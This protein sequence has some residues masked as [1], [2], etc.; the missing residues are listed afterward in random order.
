ME[1]LNQALKRILDHIDALLNQATFQEPAV[2][3]RSLSNPGG[4]PLDSVERLAE[5]WERLSE[6][7]VP[8]IVAKQHAKVSANLLRLVIDSDSVDSEIVIKAARAYRHL[9]A[10]HPPFTAE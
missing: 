5:A 7:A 10:S 3:T 6:G 9:A 4:S 8:P 1:T 2:R